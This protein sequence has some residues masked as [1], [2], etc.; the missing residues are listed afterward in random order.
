MT[1]LADLRTIVESG[2][3]AAWTATPIEWQGV[4]FIHPASMRWIRC[5]ILPGRAEAETIG[6]SGYNRLF[7]AVKINVFSP[8]GDGMAS[9]WELA[10]SVRA[11]FNRKVMTS[12]TFGAPW[13]GTIQVEDDRLINIPVN[14]PFWA[15]EQ[16]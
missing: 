8:L 5:T 2:L 9:A 11:V 14:A 10:D 15:W 16:A 4:S 6:I 12:V 7:G 1:T 13:I 3:N